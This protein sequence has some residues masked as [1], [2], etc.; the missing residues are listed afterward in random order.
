MKYVDDPDRGRNLALKRQQTAR[1]AE[2]LVASELS[3]RGY[4]VTFLGTHHPIADFR[5]ETGGGYSFL[6]DAKGNSKPNAWAYPDKPRQIE[7]YYILVELWTVPDPSFY[8]LTQEE[9]VQLGRQYQHD[10]PKNRNIHRGGFG[11]K[12]P[13]PFKDNWGKL[14]Q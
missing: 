6:V 5:V 1:A 4:R 11:R 7:L 14:P 2:S 3:N 12:Y 13:Y 8:I 10:Y 9:S